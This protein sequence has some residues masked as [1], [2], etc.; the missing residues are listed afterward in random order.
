M[1]T[2]IVVLESKHRKKDFSS[3]K[4]M[5]DHYLHFQ[6][7]QDVRKKLSAC[8]IALEPGNSLIQGYYTLSNYGLPLEGFTEHQKKKWP[9]SYSSIPVTLLG[10]L[11]VD[12]RFQGQGLGR[13]LL[14][15]ALHRSYTASEIIGSFAVVVDPLDEEA[16]NFYAKYGFIKLPDSGKMFMAM[17]TI[18]KIFL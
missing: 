12:Q 9:K 13:L 3:G 8:F 6:A 17:Q 15:D 14:M 5:L 11:A 18:I 16:E 7:G 2:E 4:E 1:T 10:R